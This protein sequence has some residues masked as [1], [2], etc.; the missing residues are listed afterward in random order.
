MMEVVNSWGLLPDY[1]QQYEIVA[2]YTVT[3]TPAGHGINEWQT[4]TLMVIV[5][6]V[7]CK[8]HLMES[9]WSEVLIITAYIINKVPGKSILETPFT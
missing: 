7:M 5:R 9:L 2:P 4:R 1:I 8:C 3:V 6:I